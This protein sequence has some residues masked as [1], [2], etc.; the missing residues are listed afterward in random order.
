MDFLKGL[1]YCLFVVTLLKIIHFKYFRSKVTNEPTEWNFEYWLK[2]NWM[3]YFIQVGI[4]ILFVEFSTEILSSVNPIIKKFIDWEIPNV[5][6]NIYY[7]I[8]VP[9]L[10]T[11]ITYK[12]LRKKI[13]Q[14]LQ[15]KV[16]PH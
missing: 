16:T 8:L 10:I 4:S 6:N 15:N 5:N 11:V 14:P 13:S 1:L 3:D 9:V 12:F 2:N 7:F